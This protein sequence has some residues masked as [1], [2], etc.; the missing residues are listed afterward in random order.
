MSECKCVEIIKEN[1]MLKNKLLKIREIATKAYPNYE[2]QLD[3]IIKSI[4]DDDKE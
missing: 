4:D 1:C 2:M 3:D